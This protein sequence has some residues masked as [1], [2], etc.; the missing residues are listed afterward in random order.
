[1]NNSYFLFSKDGSAVKVPRFH[2]CTWEFRNGSALIEFGCEIS[3]DSIGDRKELS[4][5]LFA[6]WLN[7]QSRPTDGYERLRDEA[8][9]RLI[10]NDSIKSTTN[11]NGSTPGDGIQVDFVDRKQ[12]C[13]LPVKLECN[14]KESLF[15]ITF[16]LAAYQKLNKDNRPNIYGRFIVETKLGH[17]STRKDGIGKS[18]IIYDIK[19]NERRNIPP[20]RINE[21][22]S[23]AFCTVENC[24]CLN[25]VPNSYEL[26]F[27]DS[28][29]LKNVRSLESKPFNK[30]LGKNLVREDELLVVFNKR[31]RDG[32]FSFFLIFAKE[33]IGASQFVA[34]ILIDLL[35]GVLLLFASPP[36]P[37]PAD[38]YWS[39]F[40]S[41]PV[42]FWLAIGLIGVTILIFVWPKVK[43]AGKWIKNVFNKL[44]RK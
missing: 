36:P 15:E 19:L 43:Q 39:K 41:M 42:E 21:L 3:E 34:A 4:L 22:Q 20:D 30:Y 16:S 25:I 29:T 23:K 1:M 38:T 9:L 26:S 37:K 18:T 14:Q 24:F 8:N 28:G 27:F 2:I 17:I 32:Q 6:P 12:L 5:C 10:F 44:L 40:S 31:S 7:S 13:V 11:I 35:S 33:R